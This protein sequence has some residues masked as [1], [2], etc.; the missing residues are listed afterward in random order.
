MKFGNLTWGQTEAL[1][2]KIGGEDVVRAILADRMRFEIT[3][4]SVL[5]PLEQV[6][7]DPKNPMNPSEFF[8]TRSGLWVSDRAKDLFLSATSDEVT[9]TGGITI[10]PFTLTEQANDKTIRDALPESH[11]F[12]AD[13]LAAILAHLIECQWGG[14]SGILDEKNYNWNLFYVKSKDGQVFVVGVY[15]GAGGRECF[16][17]AWEAGDAWDAVDRIF[18]RLPAQAGNCPPAGEAG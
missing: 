17:R 6:T 4:K 9:L 14:K 11:V 3:E 8:T 7:L 15:W 5:A 2:N 12:G 10:A 1:I 16:V 13:E 18:S